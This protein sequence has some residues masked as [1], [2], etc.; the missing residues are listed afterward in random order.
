MSQCENSHMNDNS[1]AGP[2]EQ[3]DN[4][5]QDQHLKSLDGECNLWTQTRPEINNA[6]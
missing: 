1:T 5:K 3:P 4:G 6:E 2:S